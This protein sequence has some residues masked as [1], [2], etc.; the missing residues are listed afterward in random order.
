MTILKIKIQKNKRIY[1]KQKLMFLMINVMIKD[2]ITKIS[3]IINIKILIF[4]GMK[5]T[6][7]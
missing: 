5:M 6:N 4:L 1:F 7:N 3:K 2:K